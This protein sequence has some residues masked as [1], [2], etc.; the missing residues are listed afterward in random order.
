MHTKTTLTL[1]AASTLL[2][3]T[4]CHPIRGVRTDGVAVR[5]LTVSQHASAPVVIELS[6]WTHSVGTHGEV[7]YPAEGWEA[8]AV[9]QH[10]DLAPVNLERRDVG[11]YTHGDQAYPFAP[12]ALTAVGP[13]VPAEDRRG[14][15]EVGPAGERRPSFS[16]A[17]GLRSVTVTRDG[18]LAL[19]NPLDAEDTTDLTTATREALGDPAWTPTW[20]G[21]PVASPDMNRVA[22][23]VDA[24]GAE[25][26]TLVRLER[27]APGRWEVTDATLTDDAS[28]RRGHALIRDDGVVGYVRSGEAQDEVATLDLAGERGVVEVES[29]RIDELLAM[30]DAWGW[31]AGDALTFERGERA[32]SYSLPFAPPSPTGDHALSDT[33]VRHGDE[34]AAQL[35]RLA[36][37]HAHPTGVHVW[38]ATPQTQ[39]EPTLGWGPSD[40][41]LGV[42]AVELCRIALDD[43]LNLLERTCA[44]FE[45]P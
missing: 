39:Q 31:R 41:G 42:Y 18:E 38:T 13:I 3:A 34:F 29:G 44:L 1:L 14:V 26:S 16:T 12:R 7:S 11:P 24:E 9:A 28:P 19:T 43:E 5:G 8:W 36:A 17:E 32:Y 15:F 40:G 10:G 2:A 33:Y 22:V 21:A 20:A 30:D 37:L 23:W 6:Y 4:G 27:G 25:Q 35:P 45:R